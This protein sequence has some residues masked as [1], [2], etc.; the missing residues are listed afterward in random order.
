[1]EMRGGYLRFQAQYLRRIRLPLWKDVSKA[2]RER[3]VEAA[4]TGDVVAC[5]QAAFDLYRLTPEESNV[6]GDND[7]RSN[8]CALTWPIMKR[9]PVGSARIFSPHEVL[10]HAGDFGDDWSQD[11]CNNTRGT[12]R[13]GSG[14]ASL[15]TVVVVL[16]A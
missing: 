16:M 3:L 5:N 10:G 13:R 8:Q 15:E 4:S 7:K 2:L 9:R 11:V 1:M 6:I 14:E 12:Y